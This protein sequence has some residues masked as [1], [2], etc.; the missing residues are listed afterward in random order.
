MSTIL[1]FGLLAA[2][3]GQLCIALLNLRLIRILGWKEE[4]ARV[5]LLMREVFHVHAWFISITLLIFA[6]LTSRFA[7]EIAL[8][9]QPVYRW[10]ACC[11]GGFWAIRALIQ[12]TYYSSSH[13]RGIGSRTAAHFILLIV[14]S[15]FAAVYLTAGL[16]R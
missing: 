14:Y 12:V 6:A 3:F 11:I 15:G 9:D 2:A 5:P 10:L 4:L 16:R 13:W 8:G 1:Q 7:R